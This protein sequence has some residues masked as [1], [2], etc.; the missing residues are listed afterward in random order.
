MARTVE[1]KKYKSERDFQNDAEKMIKKGFRIEG[2]STRTKNW[3]FTTGFLT[4][5]GITTVTW[6]KEPQAVIADRGQ[7]DGVD[8]VTLVL[9]S[10]PQEKEIRKRVDHELLE[11]E[12]LLAH[13]LKPAPTLLGLRERMERMGELA[14][15]VKAASEGTPQ[16][17][18]RFAPERAESLAS[19][20][21]SAGAKVEL[22]APTPAHAIE[23]GNGDGPPKAESALTK[24]KQ[25]AELHD[26]GVVSDQ[27]FEAKKAE[28][29]AQI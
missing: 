26:A 12:G 9:A 29:L 7:S 3:S 22:W 14:K 1:I 17:I 2:Q 24:L 11:A 25:L 19:I 27:E 8:A 18:G 10:V 4:N 6:V 16:A 23:A 15:L 28:L 21:R 13:G 5:K 20:L